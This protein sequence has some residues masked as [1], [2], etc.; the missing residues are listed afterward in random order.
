MLQTLPAARWVGVGC[1]VLVGH[2]RE[3]DAHE[4]ML[5]VTGCSVVENWTFFKV[6]FI[7]YG[8]TFPDVAH[9]P[10][11]RRGERRGEDHKKEPKWQ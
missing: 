2:S 4:H 7:S 8:P 10:N 5:M 9:P 3:D 11:T 6:L 1:D